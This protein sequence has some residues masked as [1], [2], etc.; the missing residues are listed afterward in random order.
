MTIKQKV[1]SLLVFSLMACYSDV[2]AQ[3]IVQ[4]WIDPCTGVTQTAIFPLNNTGVLIMY[5]GVSR[6]F[7]AQQAAAG[8]LQAWITQVT[9]V[10][11]CPVTSNPVIT[12]T[13][14]QTATQ[15]ATQA[16]SA[17][18]S[19][20]AG[21]AASSA[22]GGAASSAAGGAASSSTPPS[23][24]S[25]SSSTS[26]SSSSETSSGSSESSNSSESKSESSESSSEEQKEEKKEG[27][28][29][30]PIMVA[31]DFTTGQNPDGSL[32]GLFTVG[33]SQSSLMGDK[34]YGA[35]AIV[36]TSMD[37]AALSGSYTKM[38][39]KK[40][41]LNTVHNYSSTY[42]YLDGVQ[43]VLLGYTWVKPDDKWGVY[44]VNAGMITLFM[45]EGGGV[46]YST[47]LVG[48][49]MHS[50][51][52]MSKRTKLSPQLFVIVSPISYNE[53]TKLTTST[54]GS[55]MV[56][57]SMDYMITRRF[58]ATVAHRMMLSPKQKTLNFLMIGSRMTL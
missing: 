22:A 10:I 9:V 23:T 16:A 48:F 17:A 19:S 26:T 30:N 12:Q 2:K 11:P 24:S 53:I 49:W 56:G 54:S 37:Q 32:T 18:A 3:S 28:A 41:K 57:N 46:N 47:S 5:R 52:E 39:F 6:T 35:T 29:S 34:S 7:T 8:E 55:V 50:P 13:T 51:I 58:G 25:S 31:S 1:L 44:G 15:A 38:G 4:T 40:G 36:W 20:A 42:A 21:G 43:M 14:T 45:P 27:G 33:V